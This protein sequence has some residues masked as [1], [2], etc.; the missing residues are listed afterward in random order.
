MDFSRGRLVLAV[1]A[2]T[3]GKVFFQKNTPMRGRE[4]AGALNFIREC[5]AQAGGSLDDIKAWSVGTGP[6]SFTGIRI[7]ASLVLGI[8]TGNGETCARGM[9]SAFAPALE[10]A[11]EK[12]DAGKIAVLYDGR[13]G[14]LL[15]FGVEINDGR[16]AIWGEPGTVAKN[17]DGAE[18]DKYDFFAGFA[19]EKDVI[20]KAAPGL[21]PDKTKWFRLVSAEKFIGQ[22]T[23]WDINSLK[24]PFYLQQSVR[25]RNLK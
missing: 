11:A 5:L 24:K 3:D 19:D 17:G 20:E 23:P 12:P 25:K 8:I 18:L 21:P 9:P 4:S 22:D 10:L 16:A 15:C 7:L 14:D 2:R 13:L 6:G 1:A